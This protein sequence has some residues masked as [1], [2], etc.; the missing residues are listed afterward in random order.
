MISDVRILVK[1]L[2][3]IFPTGRL[4]FL[5]ST[6][7]KVPQI[8]FSFPSQVFYLQSHT[9]KAILDRDLEELSAALT[10]TKNSQV[11]L[12]TAADIAEWRE[13]FGKSSVIEHQIEA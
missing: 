8:A 7:S 5:T 13:Q 3:S 10:Q 4:L 6:S 1:L 11:K 2:V 9:H 12:Y